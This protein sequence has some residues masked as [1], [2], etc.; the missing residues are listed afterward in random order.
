MMKLEKVKDILEA[1]VLCGN[2]YL[3]KEIK[4]AYASDLMS[5]VL[6]FIK[7]GS[8]LLTGLTNAQVVRTAE[9]AEI[10]AICFVNNKRPQEETMKLANEKG[11]PFLATK[12]SMYECCGRLYKKG[13]PGVNDSE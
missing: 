11:I 7:S 9:M 4:V 8:L 5:D 3:N 6:T 13:L 1:E 2:N 12:L 10:G